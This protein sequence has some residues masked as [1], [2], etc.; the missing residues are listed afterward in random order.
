MADKQKTDKS[1]EP[2]SIAAEKL[3]KLLVQRVDAVRK[4]E[5]TA[6]RHLKWG[7]YIDFRKGGEFQWEEMGT[8]LANSLRKK[9]E[10]A[11]TPSFNITQRELRVLR[12]IF[13][14]QRG[15]PRVIKESDEQ[16]DVLGA[17]AANKII[18]SFSQNDEDVV[19]FIQAF[20]WMAMTG[21]GIRKEI[22]DEYAGRR[23][24]VPK[25]KKEEY[26]GSIEYTQCNNPQCRNRIEGLADRCDRCGSDDVYHDKETDV[27]MERDVVEGY[28]YG[29]TGEAKTEVVPSFCVFFN[30]GATSVLDY[31][32]ICE[33]RLRSTAYI[34]NRWRKNV[35]P[36]NISDE[37]ITHQRYMESLGKK[38]EDDFSQ[39]LGQGYARVYEYYEKPSMNFPDGL[40]MVFTE[41]ERLYFNEKYKGLPHYHDLSDRISG[42]NKTLHKNRNPRDV[43]DKEPPYNFFVWEP[44]NDSIWG[45]TVIEDLIDPQKVKNGFYSKMIQ[46]LD[47]LAGINFFSARGTNIDTQKLKGGFN[48]IRFDPKSYKNTVLTPQYVTMSNMP[49]DM[50]NIEAKVD[51]DA[52][53]QVGTEKIVRGELPKGG[54][55]GVALAELRENANVPFVTTFAFMD[56]AEMKHFR[57]LLQIVQQNYTEET[58][59]KILGKNGQWEVDSFKG[60]DIAGNTDVRIEM[61][62]QRISSTAYRH[63]KQNDFLDR[64]IIM[65][66]D[67]EIRRKLLIESGMEHL[68]P[69]IS[70]DIEEA[71]H[72]NEEL[73]KGNTVY[74]GLYDEHSIHYQEHV[75]ETKK[76]WFK[77]LAQDDP[78]REHFDKHIKQHYE[79]IQ[80]QQQRQQ[81][82]QQQVQQQGQ[83]EQPEQAG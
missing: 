4:D 2:K 62:P 70:L 68:L 32:W 60:Q 66:D 11:Y 15:H 18:T 27:D 75:K 20:D 57:T 47:K 16:T 69:D 12:G 13:L 63:T 78:L 67:P 19:Q 30:K 82:A 3:H 37:E 81:E 72:E 71:L 5:E 76:P 45:K 1:V 55:T 14:S 28:E 7:Y 42:E 10:I 35:N 29:Y 43:V 54:L 21:L 49:A 33:V 46:Y 56:H 50:W 58:T 79:Q 40:F 39:E 36:E 24:K 64:R 73:S 52:K 22:F 48:D 80:L 65:G 25:Y 44:S 8:T 77:E 38:E 31:H 53:A 74:M 83:Q 9:E 61:S 34:W 26:K 51:A 17:K 41:K 59:L 23:F 6:K